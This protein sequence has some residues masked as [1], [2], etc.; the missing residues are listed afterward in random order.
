MEKVHEDKRGTIYLLKFNGMLYFILITNKGYAR[1]GDLHDF[2]QYNF[3]ISGSFEVREQHQSSE[4]KYIVNEREFV[5][6]PPNVPH[7]F[8][9]LEDSLMIEWHS[10]ELPPFKDKKYH[11]P[12][13][14][15]CR[16]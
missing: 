4:K 8:I 10:K 3:V 1:G 7:V 12:Y 15:L 11:E 13:R 9:A 5:T 6:I 14:K 2:E 16:K